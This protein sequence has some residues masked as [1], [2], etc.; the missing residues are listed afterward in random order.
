MNNNLTASIKARN[1]RKLQQARKLQ[2]ARKF[3]QAGKLRQAQTLQRTRTILLFSLFSFFLLLA[4]ASDSSAQ[5]PTPKPAPP[6]NRSESKPSA[7]NQQASTAKAANEAARTG[8]ITGR[9]LGD[10]GR[11]VANATITV[12]GIGAAAP[13]T[14]NTTDADGKFK[15]DGLRPLSYSVQAFSPGYILAPDAGAET[16]AQRFYHIG[17]SVNLTMVKGGVIT[18]TVTDASGEAVVAVLVRAIP[19]LTGAK[20][21]D[22]SFFTFG[23]PRLTD[24]RGV[25]RLYGLEP[26]VYVI[27]VGGGAQFMGILNAH[28]GNAPTYYPSATRDTAAELTVHSGEELTGIDVR[29]RAERGHT[30]SG[31]VSGITDSGSNFNGVSINLLRTASGTQ[32]SFAFIGGDENNRTFALNGIADGE[33][34]L[35]AARTPGTS[36]MLTSTRK[37]SVRGADVTGLELKLEALGSL[38]GNVALD[39]PPKIDCT[40]ERNSVIEEIIIT[41]RRDGKQQTKEQTDDG[42]LSLLRRIPTSPNDKGE[43]KVSNL[44]SGNH[45]IDIQ[46]PGDD[47]YVRAINAPNVPNV[48]ATPVAKVA[49]T[50]QSRTAMPGAFTLKQGERLAGLSISIGQGAANL[51]GR[52]SAASEGVSLPARLRVYLVP[53]EQERAA[54]VLRYAE[55]A[56]ESDGRF[57]FASIAPGRYWLLARTDTVRE[58]EVAE[59]RPSGL[60]ASARDSL[61]REAE[62]AGAKIDLQPCQRLADYVLNYGATPPK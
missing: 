33:Y 9:V 31:F 11:P 36:G 10:D 7:E 44:G 56:V 20:R 62:S 46:L 14:G 34:T 35:T 18:G 8:S 24:D 28:E 4:Y 1:M 45:R 17:E 2:R 61:R 12:F 5:E 50:T 13:P 19:V 47:W 55:S 16:G 60:D 39:P 58:N 3:R 6:V 52:V 41:A 40:R 51:R 27:A 23:I 32:E 48:P 22:A 54:D 37:I 42:L 26:G 30:V 38:A 25:Y 29:Y 43:F 15:V 59:R 57:A 53:V 21:Q 49:T